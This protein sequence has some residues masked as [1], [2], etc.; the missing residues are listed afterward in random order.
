MVIFGDA[1]GPSPISLR[2]F[3]IP[4]RL[5]RINVAVPAA[6]APAL[7]SILNLL[8]ST[9]CLQVLQQL[10]GF[11]KAAYFRL[12]LVFYGAVTGR[13]R[14]GYSSHC[15]LISSQKV[16]KESPKRHLIAVTPFSTELNESNRLLFLRLSQKEETRKKKKEPARAP[17]PPINHFNAPKF[18]IQLVG[19]HFFKWLHS[20]Q[21]SKST[22]YPFDWPNVVAFRPASTFQTMKFSAELIQ[23][24][25]SVKI[26]LKRLEELIQASNF[27]FR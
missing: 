8:F 27:Q 23:L 5:G 11:Y 20:P 10:C 14:R 17:T 1:F 15:R 3:V 24:A 9:D 4:H 21:R 2:L 19:F 6:P 16:D 18:S 26:W 7:G 13:G 22:I 25:N 12:L